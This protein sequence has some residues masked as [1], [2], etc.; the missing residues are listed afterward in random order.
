MNNLTNI[1]TQYQ[2][3]QLLVKL[4]HHCIASYNRCV[5]FQRLEEN[6]PWHLLWDWIVNFVLE[7]VPWCYFQPEI[8]LLHYRKTTYK[9][10]SCTDLKTILW[11][12]YRLWFLCRLRKLLQHRIEK[13]RRVSVIY[14]S[15]GTNF[16]NLFSRHFLQHSN[17]STLQRYNRRLE[18]L[19]TVTASSQ[20]ASISQLCDT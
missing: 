11:S 15:T 10:Y 6:D 19:V 1:A 16:W 4:K 18:E 7:Q 12:H 8:K 14:S 13:W 20:Q 17:A 2:I 3:Y 9:Q 5:W